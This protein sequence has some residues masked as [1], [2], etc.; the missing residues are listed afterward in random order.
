M[1]LHVK[2]LVCGQVVKVSRRFRTIEMARRLGNWSHSE[3]RALIRFLL[4]MN[5]VGRLDPIMKNPIVL[6]TVSTSASW[7]TIFFPLRNGIHFKRR[8]T[9]LPETEKTERKAKREQERERKLL[10][11]NL[12]DAR[13]SKMNLPEDSMM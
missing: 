9:V 4:A 1:E 8:E 6:G 11:Y 2:Q 10:S 3:V 12:E 5:G 13:L 7:K